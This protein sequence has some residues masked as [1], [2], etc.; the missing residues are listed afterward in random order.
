MVL[1]VNSDK[2]APETVKVKHAP[3]AL[4]V[5]DFEFWIGVTPSLKNLKLE[6]LLRTRT[7][8]SGESYSELC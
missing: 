6:L 1:N 8:N 3:D 7:L 5:E 2:D 4:P